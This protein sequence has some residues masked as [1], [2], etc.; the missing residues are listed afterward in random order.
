MD[1][2]G[3]QLSIKVKNTYCC[4]M[5]LF[6][7][8]H[9]EL[10]YI[11]ILVIPYSGTVILMIFVRIFDSSIAWQNVVSQP[12]TGCFFQ[13]STA[14]YLFWLQVLSSVSPKER[15]TYIFIDLEL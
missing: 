3:P 13:L 14:G 7:N 6:D 4:K 2:I 5:E 11:L 15:G 8:T 1:C 9:K 10:P 12:L